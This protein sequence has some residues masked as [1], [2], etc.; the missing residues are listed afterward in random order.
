MQVLTNKAT[1]PTRPTKTSAARSSRIRTNAALA[2]EFLID[3]ES[4]GHSPKTL[5]MAAQPLP[6]YAH[7]TRPCA[8]K[9]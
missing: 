9:R 4:E 1:R 2:D 7:F 3:H 6:R 8:S 5:E